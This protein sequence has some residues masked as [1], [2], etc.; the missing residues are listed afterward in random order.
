MYLTA[1]VH[2]EKLFDITNRW[3][4]GNLEAD[5]PLVI[6]K[7]I[8]YDSFTAWEA[9]LAF[10]DTLLGSLSKDPVHRKKL[11]DKKEFKDIICGANAGGSD[12]VNELISRYRQMP[13]FFYVGSPFAGYIHRSASNG[14]LGISR[15]K[16][17]K[18]IAEK[19]SRYAALYL[20]NQVLRLGRDLA[21]RNAGGAFNPADKIPLAALMEAETQVMR[22]I[23]QQGIVLP[24]QTM[25]IKDI[26]GIKVI[27]TGFGEKGLEAAIAASPGARIVEK[28]KHAGRYDAVH[29]VVDLKTDIQFAADRFK[30]H[31]KRIDYRSR[32]LAKKGLL[33]DF[34]AF[35]K[36]GADSFQ[37]DLILTTYDELIESEIGRSMHETRIFKQRQ[38][39]RYFGNLPVNVEYIIEYLI[40]VGLSPAVEI[41]DIPIKLWGRYLPDSLSYRVRKLY[42]MSENC[43]IEI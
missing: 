27:D 20:F 36:T 38:Q 17:V 28:E 33:T 32:G 26:L 22:R 5:D 31:A 21:G 34:V 16:R 1:F 15:F 30:E 42:G 13:E 4:S 11:Y 43:L 6:T 23:R 18:R 35:M 37:V 19:A 7:I 14:I 10:M 29:Y 41:E 8:T 25:A 3:L 39:Q 24:V 2:R 9:M 40:G 12:R